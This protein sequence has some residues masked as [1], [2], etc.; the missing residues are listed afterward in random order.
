[1]TTGAVR[2]VGLWTQGLAFTALVPL[3]IA[4]WVPT[5]VDPF[6]R[7]PGGAWQAGWL[8]VASGAAIYTVC[9]TRFQKVPDSGRRPD[10]DVATLIEDERNRWP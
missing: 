5:M 1:M 3:A 10:I 2:T 7:A 8:L 4:A 9:L 6:R